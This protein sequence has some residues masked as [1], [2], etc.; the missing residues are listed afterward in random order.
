MKT[1]HSGDSHE[2]PSV[3]EEGGGQDIFSLEKLR[4]RWSRTDDTVL[5]NSQESSPVGRVRDFPV[6]SP[7]DMLSGLREMVRRDFAA[8][9]DL[10]RVLEAQMDEIEGVLSGMP[11][12]TFAH[13]VEGKEEGQ[14][15]TE[16]DASKLREKLAELEDL[17]EAF[18]LVKKKAG[19]A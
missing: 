14:G 13:D 8:F 3:R 10:L 15:D 11:V 6:T 18:M 5:R 2:T 12:G 9:A 1:I 19:H 7:V 16:V 17:L 4:Q